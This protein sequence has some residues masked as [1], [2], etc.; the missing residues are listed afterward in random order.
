MKISELN[1]QIERY[2]VSYDT[3]KQNYVDHERGTVEDSVRYRYL[4][5]I[6]EGLKIAWQLINTDK[7]P[8]D[9]ELLIIDERKRRRNEAT[10]TR[11]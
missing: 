7:P 2:V 8:K 9:L 4:D 6:Q 10:V 1:T 11:V 3:A 5:G